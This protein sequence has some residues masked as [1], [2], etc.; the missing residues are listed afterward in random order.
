MPTGRFSWRMLDLGELT[1]PTAGALSS[2]SRTSSSPKGRT[3]R[4]PLPPPRG[5]GLRGVGSQA[6]SPMQMRCKVD[7][8]LS[9][10]L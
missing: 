9:C 7:G 2:P 8:N 10:S 1:L 4:P 5:G 3:W 6:A